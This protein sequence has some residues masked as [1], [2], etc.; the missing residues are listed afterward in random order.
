MNRNRMLM[1]AFLAIVLSGL[2]AY[3]A[4]RT[5]RGRLGVSGDTLKIVVAADKLPLGTRITEQQ[6]RLA[7]WSSDAPLQGAFTNIADV[8]GRGVVVP[9]SANEPI[10]ESKLAPRQAGAGLPSAIPDGMR[11]VSVKVDDVTGVAGFVTPGT[12]V[13][14]IV[15]GSPG[16]DDDTEVSNVF[17]ENVEVLAAG[18]NVE[19]D[20]EGKPLKN[21]Q[22]VTLL[23][24]PEDS[25]KLA[26]ASAS[27]KIRLALR[28]PLDLASAEPTA[29]KKAEIFRESSMPAP[30]PQEQPKP[31]IARYPRKKAPIKPVAPTVAPAPTPPPVVTLQVELIKGD[32]RETTTFEKKQQ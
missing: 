31:V 13:D 24:S 32:K 28:N 11:A 8:V 20:A 5:L 6:L 10:L 29:V 4:Y 16:K 21:V 17:L 12:R 3:L 19:R 18:Q 2:V 27:G 25:Q 1:F 15:V 23:V 9:L 26:L 30:A 7:P 14:L 22:V